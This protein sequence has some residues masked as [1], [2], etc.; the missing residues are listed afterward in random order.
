[1]NPLTY[2]YLIFDKEAGIYN[3]AKTAA[4]I[5]GAGRTEQLHA[6]E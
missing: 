2:G 5:S 1:M 6:K 4:S 3:G